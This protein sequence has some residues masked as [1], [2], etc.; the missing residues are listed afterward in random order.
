MVPRVRR[1][2]TVAPR[3]PAYHFGGRRCLHHE[4][5][6][7]RSHERRF[8]PPVCRVWAGGFLPRSS[9]MY[10]SAMPKARAIWLWSGGPTHVVL[11]NSPCVG[12]LLPIEPLQGHGFLQFSVCVCDK[13]LRALLLKLRNGGPAS[14]RATLDSSNLRR[15]CLSQIK[16]GYTCDA[17]RRELDGKEYSLPSQRSAIWVHPYPRTG[18]CACH[19]SSSY[20][21][22]A[23][24]EDAA[25][26][27]QPHGQGTPV[28]SN[29]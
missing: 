19:Y 15:Q 21:T 4:A 5:S 18:A 13:D 17:V 24:D 25:R 9:L 23:C 2:D 29:R 12:P 16:S 26:R 8:P 6:R 27:T 7:S 1:S 10:D 14:R 11:G 28:G 20:T 22:A 3:S